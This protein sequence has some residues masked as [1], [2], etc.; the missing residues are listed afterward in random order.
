LVT[1]RYWS[2]GKALSI[3]APLLFFLISAPL[4]SAVLVRPVERMACLV[5]VI[6]HVLMGTLRPMMVADPSGATIP[7][8]PGSAPAVEQQKA[9]MDW[10][11]DRWVALFRSC[12]SIILN[13]NHPLMNKLAQ[14]AATDIG[15]SWA[16]VQPIRYPY[17]HIPVFQPPGWEQADCIAGDN[18]SDL[19]DGRRVIWL[20]SDQSVLDFLEA[21]SGVLEL[22]VEG[23]PGITAEGLYGF[24]KTPQGSL[25]WTS[26]DARFEVANA[27][28]T[29]GMRLVLTL[30]PMPLSP[31]AR[32]RLTINDW[33][34][35]EG[36]VPNEPLTVSL[37]RFANQRRLTI[38]L[39]TTPI[40]RYP[41]D[42][43]DLGVALRTLRLER[44]RQ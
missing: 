22:G 11:V 13:V 30:W 27:G 9:G 19:Q 20:I 2:A 7:G 8:L 24:E 17:A 21:R 5:V 38:D 28:A 4:L 43:R 36:L 14:L 34:A 39:K 35:F 3:A 44:S 16:S 10:R 26:G 32:L 31:D 15:L 37:D 41:R 33:T 23:H 25:R 1:G 18:V 6:G 40:T 29:P 12:K 42:P